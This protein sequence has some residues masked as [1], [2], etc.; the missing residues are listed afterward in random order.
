MVKTD[1]HMCTHTRARAPCYDNWLP[2]NY[3]LFFFGTLR[4]N[5]NAARVKMRDRHAQGSIVQHNAISFSLSFS[6]LVHTNTDAKDDATKNKKREK[7]INTS[8]MRHS[9]NQTKLYQNYYYKWCCSFS[10]SISF[11]RFCSVFACIFWLKWSLERATECMG[12]LNFSQQHH[13]QQNQFKKHL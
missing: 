7:E 1:S 11:F 13:H 3:H 6:Q 5:R 12:K 9:V 10:T 2:V 8:D 4:A